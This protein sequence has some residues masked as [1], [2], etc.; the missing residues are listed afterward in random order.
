VVTAFVLLW[1]RHRHDKDGVPDESLVETGSAGAAD[2]A[3]R[4][5]LAENLAQFPSH[6][7]SSPT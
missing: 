1:K 7:V 3:V 5:A 6:L 4:R 2:A